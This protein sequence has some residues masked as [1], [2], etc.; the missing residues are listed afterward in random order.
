MDNKD[1]YKSLKRIDFNLFIFP[2]PGALHRHVISHKIFLQMCF[3]WDSYI[4]LSEAKDPYLFNV[5]SYTDS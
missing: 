1:I 4:L 2:A 5:R 3:K